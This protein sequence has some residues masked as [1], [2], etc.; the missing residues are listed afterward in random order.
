MHTC[1]ESQSFLKKMDHESAGEGGT[2]MGADELQ[3][4]HTEHVH[5]MSL[6]R[7]EELSTK[8]PPARMIPCPLQAE[9]WV[10]TPV[11]RW[12][13]L[14]ELCPLAIIPW[15]TSLLGSAPEL[16]RSARVGCLEEQTGGTLAVE[17]QLQAPLC[18]GLPNQADPGTFLCS[19]PE[20]STPLAPQSPSTVPS[21]SLTG[22]CPWTHIPSPI[23][24]KEHVVNSGPEGGV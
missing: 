12:L 7:S 11:L 23:F 10:R 18:V 22:P 14:S 19:P 24:W 20:P 9:S 6:H 16:K 2:V 17:G 1:L 15:S 21:H 5:T 13:S 3:P 4:G 8:R